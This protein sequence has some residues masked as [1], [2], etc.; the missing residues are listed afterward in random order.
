MQSAASPFPMFVSSPDADGG[1]ELI[2]APVEKGDT[3]YEL[4]L[5]ILTKH[6][7]KF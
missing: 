4:A 2:S 7:G 5:K 6:P 3:R 1:G